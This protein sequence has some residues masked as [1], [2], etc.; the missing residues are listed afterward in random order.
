MEELGNELDML[1]NSYGNKKIPKEVGNN[2]LTEDS[3]SDLT[4]DSSNITLEENLR[5]ED[6]ISNN[7]K[8]KE[9]PSNGVALSQIKNIITKK[10]QLKNKSKKKD[11]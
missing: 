3:N 10:K 7:G 2:D 6:S 11:L 1:L 4:D 8:N 5:P 9:I